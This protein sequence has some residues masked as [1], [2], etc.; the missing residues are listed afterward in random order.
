MKRSELLSLLQVNLNTFKSYIREGSI[1]KLS[2]GHYAFKEGFNAEKCKELHQNKCFESRSNKMKT[3]W[4]NKE[5]QNKQSDSHKE[6]SIVMWQNDDYRNKVITSL[7]ESWTDDKKKEQSDKLKQVLSNESVKEKQSNSQ[8]KRWS[9][10]EERERQKYKMLDYYK[11]EENRCKTSKCTKEALKSDKVRLRISTNTKIGQ[12]AHNAYEKISNASINMWKNLDTIEKMHLAKKRNSSYGLSS[13]HKFCLE[14]LQSKNLTI[15]VEKQYP[16]NPTLHCDIYIKEFDLWIELHYHWTHY[17]EPF[18]KLN[19]Q[20]LDY[21]SQLKQKA[22]ETKQKTGKS[23]TQYDSAITTWTNIDVRKFNCAKELS[24]N[25]VCFYTIEEF[26]DYFSHVHYNDK[27]LYPWDNYQQIFAAQ[28]DASIKLSGHKC[29]VK[30]VSSKDS[31]LFLNKYHY[32]KALSTNKDVR[33]GLF[34]ND[35]LVALATFGKPRYNKNY[36][37]EALRYCVKTNYKI[38]G[39]ASK[40]YKYFSS[41]YSPK[42]IVSYQD[43]SKFNGEYHEILGYTLKSIQKSKHWYNFKTKVHFTDN[44][45]RRLGVDALLNTSY[46]KPEICG[47]SNEQL[48]LKLGFKCIIDEG[49]K[50]Y[51]KNFYKE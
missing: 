28:K 29:F 20:H 26:F 42:S 8:T 6:S 25:Y 45:V 47:L 30:E 19:A 27:I 22:L 46:G 23:K 18:N 40:L 34:Y 21:L 9:N 5:Y 35:E 44:L 32:Q 4:S 1:V 15:E 37:W 12:K 51:V 50:T 49:Q 13:E 2:R 10:K 16:D 17:K 11:S 24:L 31:K 43:L 38:I 33:V 36:E 14:W 7:K 41:M 39:G 3:L 48:L